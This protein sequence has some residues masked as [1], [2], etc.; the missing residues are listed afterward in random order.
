M[1]WF[2]DVF[3]GAG[4]GLL[5]GIGSIVGGLFGS[6]SQQDANN[7]NA[8][9]QY[10]FAKNGIQ[11]KVADAKAAGVHPLFALGAQTNMASPSYVGDSVLPG[12]LSQA[13]QDIGRAIDATRSK[14]D[15]FSAR[16]QALQVQRGELENQLLAS[17]IAKLNASPN[18]SMPVGDEF[19][20]PGQGNSPLVRTDPSRI[21]S[22]RSGDASMEAAPPSPAVKQFINRD[23]S[24]M[25]WPSQ[26]AK[27]AIEDVTPYEIEHYYLNRI[28]PF[29]Q[30]YFMEV[31]TRFGERL[32]S[33]YRS[34]LERERERYKHGY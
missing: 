5:S 29:I 23:G 10:D 3:S 28:A 8:A 17:Q 4:G 7:A 32:G 20:I 30:E 6:E 22:S 12:A 15:R 13:G 27:N 33:R 14:S 24:I 11:W 2:S 18:P 9:L 31:P 16:M 1:G 34:W 25:N 19:M 21:T 26:D